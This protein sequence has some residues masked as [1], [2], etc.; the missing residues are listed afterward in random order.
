[1]AIDKHASIPLTRSQLKV[2]NTPFANCQMLID[3]DMYKKA[4]K[5]KSGENNKM[6]PS[7]SIFR[8]DTLSM[9][10]NDNNDEYIMLD[11]L[12][13]S[14]EKE[15]IVGSIE[16]AQTHLD[17]KRVLF[18]L[19]Y[20]I[21]GHFLHHFLKDTYTMISPHIEIY[22]SNVKLTD[23]EA[24]K[25]VLLEEIFAFISQYGYT[26]SSFHLDNKRYSGDWYYKVGERYNYR[27]TESE[28]QYL[29]GDSCYR[30]IESDK[31]FGSGVYIS[32]LYTR[33]R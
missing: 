5:T 32:I 9:I 24:C 26:I 28:N 33:Y 16:Y 8:E 18:E 1:M 7:C 6:D 30:V 2:H 22:T 3:S 13:H 19:C 27:A 21:K 20:L 11:K 10:V 12:G 23:P 17:E 29:D 25:S 4:C 14:V 15:L 31:D